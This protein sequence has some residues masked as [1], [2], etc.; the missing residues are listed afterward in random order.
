MRSVR[1]SADPQVI[2]TLPLKDWQFAHASNITAALSKDG[3]CADKSDTGTGKTFTALAAAR[4]LGVT[5][6]VICPLGT[7]GQW[8]D[9]SQLMGAPAEIVH[10]ERAKGRRRKVGEDKD[11]N[12]IHLSET[13]WFEEKKWGKGSFM[14]LKQRVGL[15]IFDEAHR[16][17]GSTSMESKLLIGA[18]RKAAAVL[19]MSATLLEKTT[20]MK[21]LGF[22]L[23][24][25]GLSKGRNNFMN[26]AL[27][28]GCHPG[29]F[30]G[31]EWTEDPDK[32]SAAIAKV[33]ASLEGRLYGMRRD[34]IPGFPKTLIEPYLVTTDDAEAQ[35]VA[36]RLQH[37]NQRIADYKDQADKAK[38]RESHLEE[39]LRLRQALELYKIAPIRSLTEDALVNGS[40]VIIALNFRESIDQMAKSLD[41]MD[42]TYGVYD[43]RTPHGEKER[44]KQRFQDDDL[45]VFIMQADAGAEGLNL[46]HPYVTREVFYSPGLSGKMAK[47]FFGRAHRADGAFSRQ[48]IL[49]LAGTA[50]EGYY[51]TLRRKLA[52]IDDFNN[53]TWEDSD[54]TV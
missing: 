11:G 16:C 48:R 22:A 24:L 37:L 2:P 4:A 23:N 42:L 21:A 39:T 52:N 10:Y 18:K 14:E 27:K 51:K 31:I 25:H 6:L 13:Q 26:W 45:D 20:D 49:A 3:C 38:Q 36:G 17:S 8:R 54:F 33:Q 34:E 9:A 12:D 50:E 35:L 5:P 30:G 29:V 32:Q 1:L 43:G 53:L 47:Q 28:H 19:A 46:Q 44:L 40:A 7:R 15:V 41:K